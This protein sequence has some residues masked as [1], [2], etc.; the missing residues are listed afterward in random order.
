MAGSATGGRSTD[1]REVAW[2][3]LAPRAGSCAIAAIGA[4]VALACSAVDR[5]ASAQAPSVQAEALPPSALAVRTAD[6]RWQ[7]WWSSGRAPVA[8]PAALPAVAGAVR[9][10]RASPGVEWGEL[11]L[12]GSGEAWRL[13]MVLVRIDPTVIRFS[14]AQRTRDEGTLGAWAVD[15]APAGA[16]VALNAGQFVGGD[17]WGWLVA[18]GVESQPPGVGPLSSAL[19]VDSAGGV[20]LVD[21]ADLARVR[22]RGGVR[23]AFQSYPTVLR[24]DGV[25]PPP[26]RAPGG[27]VDVAHRDSRL[28]IGEL[29]D[30]RLLVALT[31]FE[32]LGGVLTELPFGPTVPE[33]AAIMGA[34]GARSAVLL[35]GGLSGQLMVRDGGRVR[36]WRGL[37][38]VP[39][40]LV[41]ERRR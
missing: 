16:A 25:V 17:P 14:V 37:R 30:G 11:R 21:M 2:W 33:M 6:G 35:D 24:E 36:R 41:G 23:I 19:V 3:R 8:W 10:K 27:G 38:R 32:G 15:S 31:R 1:P 28:G 39:V 5:S 22:A 12:S 20:G 26:L 9:W 13:R 34:L 29:R 7:E 40:G 4:A 18:E